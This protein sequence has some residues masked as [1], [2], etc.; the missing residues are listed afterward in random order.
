MNDS[1]PDGVVE[2]A[3]AT[4]YEEVEIF[5]D[6]EE[7]VCPYCNQVNLLVDPDEVEEEEQEEVETDST[8]LVLGRSI[9]TTWCSRH[10]EATEHAWTTHPRTGTKL[11][12][13]TCWPSKMPKAP[14]R[15][16]KKI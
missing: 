10:K 3:C 7:F 13:L 14:I 12:C 2:V 4:C 11:M 15:H 5:E 8:I 16:V 9:L 6:D 1:I